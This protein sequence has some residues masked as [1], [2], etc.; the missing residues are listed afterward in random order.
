[1]IFQLVMPLST[2][3]ERT[4]RLRVRFRNHRKIL[5][6]RADR[7]CLDDIFNQIKSSASNKMVKNFLDSLIALPL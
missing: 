6:T 7:I 5:C 2:I 4:S 3:T 1:M